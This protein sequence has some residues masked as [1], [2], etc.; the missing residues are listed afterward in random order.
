MRN[1]EVSRDITLSNSLYLHQCGFE[2]CVPSH[3]FGPAVRDHYLIHCVLSGKGRFYKP[4]QCYDLTAGQGFLIVPNEKTTYTADQEDPWHYCWVG[5]HGEEAGRILK[6]CG[7][8]QDDPVFSYSDIPKLQACV[9][10]LMNFSSV[11]GNAFHSMEMLYRFFALIC[12]EGY[13]K[14]QSALISTATAA[15]DYMEKN[16]SYGIGILEV[17]QYVGLDRSQLFRCFKQEYQMSPQEYLIACRITHAKRLLVQTDLSVSEVMYSSGFN[18]LPNFSKQFKK[19]TGLSPAAFRKK[20]LP[21][22]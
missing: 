10:N 4:G 7:I 6:I 3:N 17:A 22:S 12:Q 11:G 2:E 5:F 16:H 21:F 8:G 9:Q 14:R 18:D 20:K 19:A 15:A 1:L 13:Q